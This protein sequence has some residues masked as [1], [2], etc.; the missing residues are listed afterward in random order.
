MTNSCLKNVETCYLFLI[1]TNSLY[2]IKLTIILIP[3]AAIA[4]T[5]PIKIDDHVVVLCKKLNSAV[6]IP[7]LIINV[8]IVITIKR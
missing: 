5:L 1:K 8:A 3:V 4:H 2:P 6:E 7:V